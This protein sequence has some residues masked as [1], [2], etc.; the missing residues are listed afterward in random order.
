M[1]QSIIVDTREP[2]NSLKKC[3]SYF[4]N[5]PCIGLVMD[6]SDYRVTTTKNETLLIERKTAPDLL[7]SIADGRLF[8]QA[9]KM[10]SEGE[11]AYLVVVGDIVEGDSNTARYWHKNRWI[12]SG[13]NYN[14]IQGALMT[15]QE[16]GVT[17]CFTTNFF[18]CVERISRRDRGEVRIP[19]RRVATPW[20]G[21]EAVLASLPGIGSQKSQDLIDKFNSVAWAL[22]FLTSTDWKEESVKGIGE[23]TKRR[24]KEMLGLSQDEQFIID[25]NPHLDD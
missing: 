23:V 12:D 11:W 8:N 17:V 10:K 4:E 22:V 2:Q 5:I 13:W 6:A 20:G 19:P 14:A 16:I 7:S 25:G 24:I 1:I 21:A 15:V 18:E 9:M 3:Q